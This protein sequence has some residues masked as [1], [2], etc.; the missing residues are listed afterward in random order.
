MTDALVHPKVVDES[1]VHPVIPLLVTALINVTRI[2]QNLS[3][4]SLLVVD[5]LV[6]VLIWWLLPHPSIAPWWGPLTSVVR[7]WPQLINS[8][9]PKLVQTL[10]RGGPLGRGCGKLVEVFVA[11]MLW[12]IVHGQW[13]SISLGPLP[14]VKAWLGIL[15]LSF[16]VNV[17]LQLWSKFTQSCGDHDGVNEMV[18]DTQG[19]GLLL[20]EK[21]KLFSLAF[22]NGACEEITSRWFWMV[23]FGTYLHS[24]D[25]TFNHAANLAQAAVFGIWHYHG[26][27]SGLTGVGL[28]FV[29]GFI[30]GLLFQYGEGLFLPI[31]AH[32]IAD[33]YI[34]A[35]IA[36]QQAMKK[37]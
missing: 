37:I 9:S 4:S 23:E 11:L 15:I 36:R 25:A 31:V 5:G 17:V 3:L 32:G 14:D 2:R 12:R 26:I 20:R 13:P 18:E 24:R 33:Y 22:L 21:V 8:N 1:L 19:R 6:S 29:Y 27:P 30:M 28:T 34:F 10:A 35:I 7:R 16:A